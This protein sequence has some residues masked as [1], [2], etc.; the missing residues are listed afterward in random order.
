MHV[1]GHL[2]PQ[3]LPLLQELFLG[4]EPSQVSW[5]PGHGRILPAAAG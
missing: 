4:D 3:D 1:V 5:A 2:A